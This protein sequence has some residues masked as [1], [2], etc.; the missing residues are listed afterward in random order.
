[1]MLLALEQ[2]RI[3]GFLLPIARET[4]SAYDCSLR[5]FASMS[6]EVTEDCLDP[7]TKR[8]EHVIQLPS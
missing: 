5:E 4:H 3:E 2:G 8:T 1:M 7:E 6:S